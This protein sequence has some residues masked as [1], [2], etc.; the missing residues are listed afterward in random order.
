MLKWASKQAEQLRKMEKKE[1]EKRQNKF[2]NDLEKG[3]KKWK[4]L[5]ILYLKKINPK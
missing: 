5:I 2:K 4:K 1:I 3:G